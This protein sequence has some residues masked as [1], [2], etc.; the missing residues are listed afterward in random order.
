MSEL[1]DEQITWWG[2]QIRQSD[3]KAFD[4]LFR[5]MYKPLIRFAIRY[6]RDS[7]SASDVVQDVFIML[8]QKRLTI[9]PE[10]SLKAYV[11]KMVRNR[12][13]NYL[14]SRSRVEINH[15]YVNDLVN[16]SEVSQQD[17]DSQTGENMVTHN[18]RSCIQKLPQ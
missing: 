9:D 3:R 13:L 2:K 5:A 1:S 11:Y 17:M 12:A 15:D 16:E 4:G 6:T 7:A 8:W 10:Q 14:R 18:I